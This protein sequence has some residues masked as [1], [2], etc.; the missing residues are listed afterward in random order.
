MHSRS[1]VYLP[2]YRA[3]AQ[4]LW[5]CLLAIYRVF[6]RRPFRDLARLPYQGKSLS[7]YPMAPRN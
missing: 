4:P 6:A 1:D 5:V 3:T 2:L 7:I